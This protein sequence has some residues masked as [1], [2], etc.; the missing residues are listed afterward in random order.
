VP[1]SPTRPGYHADLLELN[2]QALARAGPPR[3]DE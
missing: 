2:R 1:A 3:Q